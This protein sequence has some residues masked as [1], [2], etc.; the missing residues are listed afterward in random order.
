VRG[1]IFGPTSPCDKRTRRRRSP[2]RPSNSKNVVGSFKIGSVLGITVRLHW[3]LVVLV[4]FW[5]WISPGSKLETFAGI[6]VLLGVVFL[7]ELGH[8]LVARHYGIHVL[9][10]TF[11]PLGGMAR[12]SEIPEQPKV[13]A[14]I[15]IAG[16]MVNFALAALC[17]PVLVAIGLL[18]FGG[19]H[20]DWNDTV[21]SLALAF[22]FVNLALGVFNL[23]PAFP[24]DGGRVLRA[25]LGTASDWVT[26]TRRAVNVG[27][28]FAVLMALAGLFFPDR[29]PLLI[30]VAAFVWITGSRELF[31][32]RMRHGQV[33]GFAP[34]G[35]RPTS[36]FAEPPA[37]T[38]PARPDP[39]GA[40]R[41]TDWTP[42]QGFDGS[43]SERD[44]A[45]LERFQ[46]RLR[47]G[48]E[49]RSG[50]PAD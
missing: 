8:S 38:A 19:V 24:M 9:D 43:L 35:P 2:N 3:L 28:V 30:L 22:F 14:L 37:P 27:R 11:W 29:F 15:A 5:I 48:G 21:A 23:I 6:V 25:L 33:P 44:V 4:G 40:R 41:P 45:Q 46:G 47:S 17:V 18:D 26:A 12:M 1:A 20:T 50:E 10:I 16:P 34:A 49:A 42:S 7:H 32:V 31:T 13:E 36:Y 39:S